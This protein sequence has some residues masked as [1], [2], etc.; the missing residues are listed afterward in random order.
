VK[1]F[2]IAILVILAVLGACA[3]LDK[4]IGDGPLP[5][6]ATAVHLGGILN[7]TKPA[8]DPP[9]DRRDYEAAL[10]PAIGILR[11]TAPDIA[12]WVT[13]HRDSGSIVYEF[14]LPVEHARSTTGTLAFLLPAVDML[15]LTRDFWEQT[16]VDKA[17]ILVHEYRHSRQNLTRKIVE[18][19]SQVLSLQIFHDPEATT[20]EDEAYLYQLSF[21]HA[22]GQEPAWLR[23]HLR[24]RGF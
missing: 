19:G 3:V 2:R 15:V 5:Q 22:L 8:E 13:R 14:A 10:Q 7:V 9:P 23:Y 18:R 21:Y 16:D 6:F 17:G 1:K 12:Q 24:A 11:A 20:L 4:F